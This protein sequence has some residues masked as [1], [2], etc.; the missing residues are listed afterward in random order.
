M[1]DGNELVLG[2]LE[3]Y[4]GTHKEGTGGPSKK[5]KNEDIHEKED[6]K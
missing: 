6:A 1:Y 5:G 4:F 3:G 2:T